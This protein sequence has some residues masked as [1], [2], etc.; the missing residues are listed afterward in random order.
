[1]IQ[2][3]RETNFD[4]F[5]STKENRINANIS[6]TQIKHLVKFIN[7][8]DGTVFYS[9]A[10][11]ENIY[12]RYTSMAFHYNAIPNK[13]TGK[14]NLIPAGYYKYEVYEV[15]WIGT[16][17]LSK[18]TAPTTETDVLPVH[19]DNGVVE[20]LVE[21]GKLYLAEKDG[22]E[23]VQY[24]QNAKRVQSL[25]IAFG[26]TGY[27]SAPDVVI[28]AP[29]TTGGHQATATCTVSAGAINTVTITYAGSGYTTIPVVT[30]TGGGFTTAGNI[31]ATIDETNYIYYGQ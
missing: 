29:G 8:L 25:N 16:V 6:S 23:E 31:T 5:I 12:D 27:A 9:Y 4:A 22:S 14:I 21:I 24:T 15:S 19:N 13:F 28:A 20:G 2:A 10:A 17:V 30:L 3:I 1:M 7:D 11:L 18:A 26:G